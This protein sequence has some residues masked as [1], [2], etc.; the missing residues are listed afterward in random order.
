MR[1]PHRVVVS[2][3]PCLWL[4]GCAPGPAAGPAASDSAAATGGSDGDGTDGTEG[5][6]DWPDPIHRGD[7]LDL[8]VGAPELT[9]AVVAGDLLLYAGQ[10]QTGSGGIWAF[11]IADRDAPRLIGRGNTWH[12]QRVCWTGEEAWGMSRQG[13][14]MRVAVT[15]DSVTITDRFPVAPWGAGLD[16]AGDRLAAAFNQ[17]GARLY[18]VEG[19]A[20][21]GLVELGRLDHQV[22]DVMMEGDRLW[23][24]SDG[25]LTA[26][27]LGD[28]GLV[29]GGS[30][31]LAGTC[32]DLSPGA[33]WVAV[34]CG[35]G[36][37]A[38]VERNDGQPQL[39][40][41]WR[42]HISARSVA[43]QGDHVL[44]AGWT[45]L[46]LLDATDSAAPW[47]RGSEPAGSSVMAVAADGDQRAWVA[48]WN[49][50]FSVTWDRT[51][52]P[53]VR[54]SV[55]SALPDTSVVLFNDGPAPLGLYTPSDGVLDRDVVDP[56]GFAL[57]TLSP[58]AVDTEQ[59]Q[60]DDPDEPV[61]TIAISAGDGMQPGAKAPQFVE[62]DLD[63]R[64]W[65]LSSLAGSVVFLAMF[66]DGCPTCASEVP[67]TDNWIVENYGEQP[68][69]VGLWSYGGPADRARTWTDEAGIDLPV[70][71][72][73][74]GSMRMD[75]FI[76]NGEDAFA[77][78]P[79]HYVIDTAGNFAYVQ[80]SPNPGSLED[81][82]DRA[83]SQAR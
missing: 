48:D 80:T 78:N 21:E 62:P 1:I 68:N 65:D 9:D 64:S 14:L 8:A 30:V 75:Y 63:G 82:L 44:V 24:L 47:M 49:Q 55:G 58:T 13:E 34:A 79:R 29:A 20:P 50:P 19:P 72:D 42:G 36:G 26:Y 18:A 70:L 56:G 6:S 3:V 39:L 2:V 46:V 31:H 16:C 25:M 43:A 40:S 52:S 35:S 22:S 32:R 76:P 11:D 4:G 17:D 73:E 7:V 66:N 37:V 61:V 53:E 77:A 10:E 57:W 69:F 83:L 28:D 60:T 38:L 74:D 51:D 5:R 27:D 71:V 12:L 33:D 23:A 41:Q 45:E 59:V 67:D 15:P 54:P 81:A